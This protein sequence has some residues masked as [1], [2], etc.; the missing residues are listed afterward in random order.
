MAYYKAPGF[1]AFV[2]E[3]PLTSTQK[4]QRGELRALV[5]AMAETA[6]DTRALKRR[7]CSL[8]RV[9]PAK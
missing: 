7:R 1:I 6:H 8:L 4:I 5:A 2:E 9:W 3:V